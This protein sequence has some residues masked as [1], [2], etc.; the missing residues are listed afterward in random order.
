VSA[1]GL[2]AERTTLEQ[3]QAKLEVRAAVET[4]GRATCS[5]TTTARACASGLRSRRSGGK[6]QHSAAC[7]CGAW[8]S[9]SHEDPP[10]DSIRGLS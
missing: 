6:R 7:S 8:V 1:A 4:E 3:Q 5:M 2:V 9:D 10:S